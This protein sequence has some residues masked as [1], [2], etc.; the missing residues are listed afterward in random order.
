MRLHLQRQR[1]RSFTIAFVSRFLAVLILS[2][3]AVTL[4]PIVSTSAEQSS[5]PCCAGKS[6]EHCDSGLTAAKPRPVITEPMCGLPKPVETKSHN[7]VHRNAE[8]TSHH[9]DAESSTSRVTAAESISEPC[10]MDC[11]ACAT[12]TVRQQKRQKSF[13]SARTAYAPLSLTAIQFET[14]T[15]FFSTNEFWPLINPRGPP[16]E[17]L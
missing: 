5:M 1:L 3:F 15:Q 10:R 12:A 6:S 13:V 16:S 11:S 14:R 7:H 4:F 8:T 9:A 17:L 2:S